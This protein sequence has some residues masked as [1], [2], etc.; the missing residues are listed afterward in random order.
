[1]LCDEQGRGIVQDW[2]PTGHLRYLGRPGS[3]YLEYQWKRS[4]MIDAKLIEDQYI[5]ETEWRAI[6]LELDSG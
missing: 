4:L 3:K 5:T 6:P 2:H 1:M